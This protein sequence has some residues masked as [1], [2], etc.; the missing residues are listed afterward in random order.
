MGIGFGRFS[1]S[2][3][4]L[5]CIAN[6]VSA[7]SFSCTGNTSGWELQIN[8]DAASF[9]ISP[10]EEFVIPQISTTDDGA[11]PR[12][13]TLIGGRDTAILVLHE[14]MCSNDRVT[15]GPYEATVLTQQGETPVI[16]S[17]C[18]IAQSD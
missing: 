14:R 4:L 3:L 9:S 7:E 1:V 17:G 16:L 8:G 13:Y 12:A 10:E 2:A 6:E 18:C 15:N 5:S 11:W